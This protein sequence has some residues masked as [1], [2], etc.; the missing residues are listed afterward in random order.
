MRC[1]LE[2]GVAERSK[3]ARV[4]QIKRVVGDK[5]S[6]RV[7]CSREGVTLPRSCVMSIVNERWR[8]PLVE[9]DAEHL[10][11]RRTAACVVAAGG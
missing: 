6:S 9:A 11:S 8:C 7:M 5:V 3:V 4:I 2:A 1:G 10:H